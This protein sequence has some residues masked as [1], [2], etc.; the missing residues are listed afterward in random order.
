MSDPSAA[1]LLRFTHH[2]EIAH[3]LP[4]RIRLKLKVPLDGEL[5]AMA[6]EAKRFG[7]AL[8]KMDGIRSISLNPLARS[9]VVEYDP[10]GIPPAAWRDFVSGDVTPEGETLRNNLHGLL[11]S[12]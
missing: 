2:L 7:K 9:C 11:A 1:G 10:H 12:S 5:I 3:H 6:D 4:G 8:A